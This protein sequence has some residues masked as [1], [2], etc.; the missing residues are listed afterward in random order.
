MTTYAKL[1]KDLPLIK[2]NKLSSSQ[3]IVLSHIID[4]SRQRQYCYA[5]NKKLSEIANCTEQT[6]KRA[7]NRLKEL[8]V[9]ETKSPNR[10][11]KIYLCDE[12]KHLITQHRAIKAD[13]TAVKPNNKAFEQ[14]MAHKRKDHRISVLE[15][16]NIKLKDRISNNEYMIAKLAE[17]NEQLND[18][19]L[20][21][22]QEI[23]Q[24]KE[25]LTALENQSN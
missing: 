5:S 7:I 3:V 21:Q 24:L 6:V 4:L 9:I 19:V 13:S 25:R 23:T 10:N 11:R 22:A 15:N 18:T 1:F 20:Q 14:A 17:E 8:K 12:Y 2:E 16:E